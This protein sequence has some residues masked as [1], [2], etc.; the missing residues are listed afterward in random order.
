MEPELHGIPINHARNCVFDGALFDR[1]EALRAGCR[2]I[3]FA[4][5]LDGVRLSAT[6]Q[7]FLDARRAASADYTARLGDG[8]LICFGQLENVLAPW[9]LIQL[10]ELRMLRRRKDGAWDGGGVVRWRIHVH[11]TVGVPLRLALW[12]YG[13]GK[14]WGLGLG[15]PG[16]DPRRW[17]D[18]EIKA[19]RLLFDG[20]L[21]RQFPP[22]LSDW[23]KAETPAHIPA[24]IASEA[25]EAGSA[26]AQ[27]GTVGNETRSKAKF[28]RLC[29]EAFDGRSLAECIKIARQS[30]RK[31]WRAR[32]ETDGQQLSNGAWVRI[33]DAVKGEYPALKSEGRRRREN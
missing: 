15:L 8:R 6:E 25:R 17:F 29:A 16:D 9:T 27:A 12:L 14:A 30:T 7:A 13:K 32:V 11:D 4:D 21:V 18:G 10:S 1:I 5:R 2:R 26:K 19:G 33:W 20:E 23:P 22:P 24:Q 3:S 31:E 28:L